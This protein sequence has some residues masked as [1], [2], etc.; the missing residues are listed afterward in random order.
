M[1]ARVETMD[2]ECAM[3]AYHLIKKADAQTKGAR[4]LQAS[5]GRKSGAF[6]LFERRPRKFGGPP[7]ATVPNDDR[8]N[9]RQAA[10]D[11][12]LRR[13]RT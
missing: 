13:A 3:V 12:T 7:P 10:T 4:S 5:V 1:N 11:L 6:R 2:R 8:I 9:G